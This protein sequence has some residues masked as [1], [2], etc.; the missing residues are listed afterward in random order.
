MKITGSSMQMAAQ[1]SYVSYR[2]KGGA[3]RAEET[4]SRSETSGT[5]GNLGGGD[6][7]GN[8]FSDQLFSNYTKNGDLSGDD[9]R[10]GVYVRGASGTGMNTGLY[11]FPG[12]EFRNTLMSLLFGR[13]LQ[14]GMFGGTGSSLSP[15]STMAWSGGLTQ[16]Q[17]N[18]YEQEELHFCAAGQALTEDG[19]TL[20]FDMNIYMSHMF[21]DVTQIRIPSLTSFLMDPLVINVG[22]V[23]AGIEDQTFRF[24]LDADGSEEDVAAL[25]SGSGFLALD[26]NEDGVI[27]DGSELFG[28][29]SGDGFGDLRA[30]DSDG[31]G[32]IDENDEIFSKLRVW[33]R[34]GDGIDELVDLK[35][36]DVGAIWLGEQETAYHVRGDG[37]QL[38]G[39][40]RSTGVFLRESG[41]VGTVQHIDLSVRKDCD[42]TDAD[43]SVAGDIGGENFVSGYGTGD[44]AIPDVLVLQTGRRNTEDK[45]EEQTTEHK[46]EET[47][48][49]K[50]ERRARAAEEKERLKKEQ[51]ERYAERK[52][53][54]AAQLEDYLEHRREEEE[55]VDELF[56]DRAEQREE[57]LDELMGSEKKIA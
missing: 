46:E 16:V 8:D 36:A 52:R 40:M 25:A 24:D 51:Q 54:N 50:A 45:D 22:S 26:K 9:S 7:D 35:E 49:K 15:I 42:Q 2:Q 23:V 41:G 14:A 18:A 37:Q 29:T 47:A 57:I 19:R 4:S 32:W 17:V 38:N 43:T 31:N 13:F 27:N 34:N 53:R 48:D 30:Y 21:A 44:R 6:G 33:Y 12:M 10:N 20:S 55:R 3:L 1:T 39:M 56:T 5:Y 28:A 11:G